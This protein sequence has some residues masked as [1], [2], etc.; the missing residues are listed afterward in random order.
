MTTRGRETDIQT[1][2]DKPKGNL[3]PVPKTKDLIAVALADN[4][5]EGAA[6]T[7]LGGG[8][9]RIARQILE[10]AFASGIKVREDADLAHVLQ[11]IDDESEIPSEAFAAVAEILIYLDRANDFEDLSTCSPEDLVRAW[12]GET[13]PP[14]ETGRG[15]P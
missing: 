1:D 13:A 7:V 2:G 3:R 9:G 10:I 5:K 12:M 15:T 4:T 8:K 11:A 14:T 6:P